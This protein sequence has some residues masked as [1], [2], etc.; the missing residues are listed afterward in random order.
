MRA[1]L[2]AGKDLQRF[3]RD[4]KALA[5]GLAFPVLL[6]F[7]TIAVQGNAGAD[8]PMLH[9]YVATAEG[10]GLSHDII[11][12]LLDIED[13]SIRTLEPAEASR[14]LEAGEIGGYLLFPADFTEAVTG[15]Y[16]TDLSVR[17]GG[18]ALRTR[19]ALEGLARDI[20][21]RAGTSRVVLD[22][23]LSLL[24]TPTAHD[25]DFSRVEGAFR[26]LFAEDGFGAGP[27]VTLES[28]RVG[29]ILPPDPPDWSVPGYVVMFLFFT[30]ALGA[31][32]I[33][34]ERR[35]NTLERLLVVGATRADIL[36][37]KFLG[38]VTRAMVQAVLLWTAGIALFGMN[39]GRAPAA[40]LVITAV[41]VFASAA[42][43][44][45]LASLVRT[46]AAAHSAAVLVSLVAAPL[47][48]CWW[49]LFLAPPWLQ[50][51]ARITPH[52]WANAAFLRTL[53]YGATLPEVL[54]E[55][56][57]I[58]LFGIAFGAVALLRFRPDAE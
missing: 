18:Q 26:E 25:V 32:S 46:P 49:P 6:I 10:S 16:G 35:N 27:A 23:G 21:A 3:L 31:E 53:I 50:D 5:F 7:F 44:V 42:F 29:P 24:A 1:W 8:D 33:V 55:V 41:F 43:G 37:G 12:V 56:A 9:L 48:G 4:P 19:Y 51:M 57:V 36:G 34:L 28:E 2:L 39:I 20:A 58:A 14:A 15:G 11:D 52:A 17:V 30:A 54:G 13:L 38:G 40:V 22:A 45:L 47:G